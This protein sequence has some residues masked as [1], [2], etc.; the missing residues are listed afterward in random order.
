MLTPFIIC[1][2]E[3][4]EI[5]LI[6]IPLVVYFNKNKMYEMNRSVFRG[7]LLGTFLSVV[8]AVITFYEAASFNSVSEEFFDGLLGIILAGLILYSIVLLRKNKTF[9]TAPDQK[10]LSMSKKG[11]FTISAITF[12][13][14]LLEANLFIL[15]SASYGSIC[16]LLLGSLAGLACAALI[17]FLVSKGVSKLNIG[18]V[19]YVLNLFL[20]GIGAYCFGDGL[21]VLIGAYVPYVLKIGIL[22]YAIPCYFIMIKKDLKKFM[23]SGKIK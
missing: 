16:L 6:I 18:V 10:L 19:F 8:I 21:E 7:G 15:G 5:F 22:V 9:S 3:G 14:E 11:I 4:L 23:N 13:R 1:L 20:I 12:F 2:R 17:V